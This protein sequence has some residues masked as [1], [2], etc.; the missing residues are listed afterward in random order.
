VPTAWIE[1]LRWFNIFHLSLVISNC[2][3]SALCNIVKLGTFISELQIWPIGLRHQDHGI[4]AGKVNRNKE[5]ENESFQDYFEEST[6]TV[7]KNL[8]FV[9]PSYGPFTCWMDHCSDNWIIWS[10]KEA[11]NFLGGP[12]CLKSLLDLTFV[13]FPLWQTKWVNEYQWVE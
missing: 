2:W 1:Q 12:P 10:G 3:S 9:K 7:Q 6:D 4:H 5:S 13:C 11:L 8:E